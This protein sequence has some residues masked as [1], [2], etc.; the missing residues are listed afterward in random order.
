M[1]AWEA[2]GLGHT[3][4]AGA[5]PQGIQG[6]PTQCPASPSVTGIH[7][8]TNLLPRNDSIP[9]PAPNYVCASTVVWLKALSDTSMEMMVSR[10][11]FSVRT[12]KATLNSPGKAQRGINFYFFFL[13]I[14]PPSA[15]VLTGTNRLHCQEVQCCS[16]SSLAVDRV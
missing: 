10:A 13:I 2:L 8:P 12:P 15:A 1:L 11:K 14:Q 6:H 7:P 16:L 4:A 5:T 3:A 9:F